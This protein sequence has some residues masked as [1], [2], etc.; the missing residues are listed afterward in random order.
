MSHTCS[1]NF[2][3]PF[4]FFLAVQDPPVV[5]DMGGSV[6]TPHLEAI[7]SLQRPSPPGH[8]GAQQQSAQRLHAHW[9]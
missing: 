6:P 1:I 4:H 7:W 9:V 8:M 5:W 3:L 2:F